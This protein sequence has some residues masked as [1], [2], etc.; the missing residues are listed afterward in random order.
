[1][2]RLIKSV[3]WVFCVFSV[4]IGSVCYVEGAPRVIEEGVRR[5]C[6]HYGHVAIEGTKDHARVVI[7]H[8]KPKSINL[9]KY[10][11]DGTLEYYHGMYYTASLRSKLTVKSISGPHNKIKLKKG[12]KVIIACYPSRKK[13]TVCKLKGGEAVY[14]PP[15]KLK[16]TG[17]IFNSSQA[18]ADAQVEE[19]V[20]SHHITSKTDYMF[21]V[22]K[23]NQHA[24]ILTKHKGNWI[25]KYVLNISTGSF[26]NYG[27]P[28][29]IYGLNS[30]A[31][32]TH[33]KNKKNVGAD[34][35]GISY[36]SKEG[37]NQ[38]HTGRTLV[39]YTHGCIAMKSK[40]YNFVYNYLPKGTRVV[41]Y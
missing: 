32:Q 39:P 1:M 16:I 11:L 38:L 7:K 24:W 26:T 35:R 40:D 18:Y 36:A 31:I 10:G 33:Y 41:L 9:S 20:A 34:G 30:L 6:N 13:N 19:W 2:K 15:K 14:I 23:F 27:N 3:L 22:S 37:G 29:D 25:C 21:V 5:D 28:N 8:N 17:Y 4:F 12:T